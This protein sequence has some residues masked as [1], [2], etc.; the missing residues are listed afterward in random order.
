MALLDIVLYP[1]DVLATKAKVV[2]EVND[3]VRKLVDDMVQ[4][5]Y[6]A[7]GIGL[8]APQIGLLHRITV[9]DISGPED[10][11]DLKVFINPEIV[12]REGKIVWE[13]GCL[14]IP[15]VY[16]KVNRAKKVIVQALDQHGQEFE[17]EA[18]ELLA[19]ALQ[20]EIDHLD[21]IVFLDHL[22]PL[23][24]RMLMKKYR[25]HLERMAL[26]AQEEQDK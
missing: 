20:H 13:E 12:H 16:E 7:P 26:E 1:N 11:A 14:S 23:K 4:T 10:Q 15:G 18:E 9:I 21:G 3:D 24:R 25:K 5:M 2:D 8:A 6:D 17:L 22:S 19:V